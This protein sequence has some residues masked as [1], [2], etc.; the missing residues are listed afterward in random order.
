MID[1]SDVIAAVRRRSAKDLGDIKAAILFRDRL[2]AMETKALLKRQ[3][4][5]ASRLSPSPNGDSVTVR[6]V[7]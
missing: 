6:R 4:R 1:L 7:R 5:K 3:E 2:R